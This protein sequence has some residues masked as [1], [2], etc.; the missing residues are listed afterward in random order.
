[1]YMRNLDEPLPFS[2]S[3]PDITFK[4]FGTATSLDELATDDLGC[5]NTIPLALVPVTEY[6]PQQIMELDEERYSKNLN[7]L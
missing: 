5:E 2:T 4:G 7:V 1:M 6:V 3:S